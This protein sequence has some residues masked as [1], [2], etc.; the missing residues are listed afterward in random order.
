[1]DTC[2]HVPDGCISGV[3]HKVGDSQFWASFLKIK[4]VFYQ[5]C[6]KKLGDGQNTRFW[7]DI[8]VDD[9]PLKIA[10]SRLYFLCFDHNIAMAEAIQKGWE[11]FRFRR[12][13]HGETLELWRNLKMRC[14]RVERDLGETY[15]C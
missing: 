3:K 12:N 6:K 8:W 2:K 11:G 13:L 1:M 9:K 7:G 10:Y 14:E 15:L 5:F 4:D